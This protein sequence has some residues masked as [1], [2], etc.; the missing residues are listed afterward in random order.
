LRGGQDRRDGLLVV[1]EVAQVLL[2]QCPVVGRNPLAVVRVDARL[3]L[4]DEVSHRERMILRGAEYQRFLVLV[5][6]LHEQL[7]PVGFAFFNLNDFVKVGFRI[8]LP[9]FDFPLDQ[10]V[11]GRIYIL[12]ERCGNLL[13]FER[14]K[15]PVVDAF[16]ER[17]DIHRFAK[18]GIG[19]LR[20][21]AAFLDDA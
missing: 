5:D 13:H 7:Y 10:L 3:H 14:G 4:V 11:I 17:V 12:I 1:L 20:S 21:Q 9:G 16:L 15:K 8:K 19:T 18:V 2:T 6:L